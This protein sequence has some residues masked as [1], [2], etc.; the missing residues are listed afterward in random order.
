MASGALGG[1]LYNTIDL[2]LLGERGLRGPHKG[3][4]MEYSNHLILLASYHSLITGAE[5]SFIKTSVFN[6]VGGN[7]SG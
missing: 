4:K 7:A 1:Y 3:C 2:D 5:P 6:H